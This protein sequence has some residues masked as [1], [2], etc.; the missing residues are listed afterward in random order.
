MVEGYYKNT[1]RANFTP[2]ETLP[3]VSTSLD[4]VRAYQF[5]VKFYGLPVE[6]RGSQQ[7]LTAAAKQVSPIGG[8][9]DDIPVD[10]VNDKT[11]LPGKFTPDP[12]T[13]TFDN[14]LL[15][16]TAP[17]LWKWFK[18]IYDPLTGDMTKFSAPG[19]AGNLSYKANKMTVVELDNTQEPHSFIEM[20]GVYPT[21]VRFSEKNYSTNDLSTIEVTFRFD[22]LDYGKYS[23]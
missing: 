10:R 14:Q 15:N 18:S 11:F 13:I 7:E 9:V 5:E 22:F 4:A 8:S 2:G 17:A 3:R 19:G 12:V 21:T 20:Y 6:V 1:T 16:Q 23:N